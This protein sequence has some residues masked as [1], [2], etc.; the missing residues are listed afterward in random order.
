MFL[1]EQLRAP[2]SQPSVHILKH[3]GNAIAKVRNRLTQCDLGARDVTLFAMI[4]LAALDRGMKNS[5]AHDLHKKNIAV[6]VSQRGSLKSL[7]DG[8]LL[9][10]YLVHYDTFWTMQTGNTIF[11]GQRRQYQPVYPLIRSPWN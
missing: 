4:F 3:K 2:G 9:K 7:P 8:S 11:P 10:T 6:M 5:A 1:Q